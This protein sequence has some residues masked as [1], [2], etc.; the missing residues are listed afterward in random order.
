M[1][2]ENKLVMVIG[3]GLLLFV[4]ILVSDHLSARDAQIADPAT[5]V[6]YEAK[7]LPGA[8]DEPVRDFGRMPERAEAEPATVDGRTVVRPTDSFA[9]EIELVHPDPAA[10]ELPPA[11]E[12]PRVQAAAERTH[13]IASGENP[14]KI[15]L[16]YYGTRSLAAKLADYNGVD[17]TRL[18]IGQSLRI[19]DISVLDPKAASG[20]PAP[21]T[22]VADKPVAQPKPASPRNEVEPARGGRT[23][24]V[25]ANDSLWKI[26]T[27]AFGKANNA[28]V[29]RIRDLNPGLNEKN[30]KIGS[31]IRVAAE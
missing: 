21:S 18:R 7:P 13:T 17:P 15:A 10:R 28:N 31:Q 12:T 23:V 4:G 30:L 1:T 29:Q 20:A 8:F 6:S 3:F 11:A 27:R 22:V 24:T 5:I 9:R 16:K 2:R 19:P 25:K 26:A 14:E